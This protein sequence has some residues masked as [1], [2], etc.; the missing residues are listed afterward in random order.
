MS[1]GPRSGG[2]F[3]KK[4]S[5]SADTWGE[6]SL[7]YSLSDLSQEDHLTSAEEIADTADERDFAD[8]DATPESSGPP[9]TPPDRAGSLDRLCSPQGPAQRQPRGRHGKHGRDGERVAGGD[10]G[11][12]PSPAEDEGS[13]YSAFTLPCRRS[14]CLSEGPPGQQGA[15]CAGMQGRRAQ[16]T[17]ADYS[18]SSRRVPGRGAELL[19]SVNGFGTRKSPR[20]LSCS[21]AEGSLLHQLRSGASLDRCET[22]DVT[23]DSEYGDS[24]IDGVG[25]EPLRQ[26]RRCKAM[27]A[28]FSVYSAAGSSTF[29]GS[30]SGSSSGGACGGPGGAGVYENFRQELERS[31]WG[32]P[33]AGE[34]GQEEAGSAASDDRNSTATASSVCQSDAL[35][36]PAHQGTVRKAGEL[37]VKNFLVHKKGKKVEPAARRKWKRYWVSLKG[38]TLFFYETDGRSGIDQNSVPKHAVWA[39]NSIV[40][41]VPEHPKKDF[42]FCLS[43]SLGDAFLFQTS[44]QT[45]LEN[46]ITAL[47]SACAAAVARQHHRDDTVRL[48][49]SEVKKLEKKMDMD[50]KMKKMGEMQLSAVTDAKKRKTILEQIF[51]WE[52]NLEQF[53]MDWF[54]LRCYLASLQGG[55]LPNP[56]R[57]LPNPKRLLACVSR[58]SKLAMGR[59][60]IFSVSSFHALVA[61]RT[62]SGVRRRTQALSRSSSKRKSRF[63]SLWGLDTASKKKSKDRPSIDQVFADGDDPVRKVL[64]SMLEDSPGASLKEEGG[65]VKSIPHHNADSDIWVPDHLTPSWVCLPDDKAQ[66]FIIQTGETALDAL[67][68]ICKTNS[69]DPRSHYLRLKFRME[70]QVRYYTPK[71]DEE[72]CDLL[73]KEIEICSKA[74]K[75]IQFD[76]DESCSIGYGFSVAV[77]E[78][79]GVQQLHV[80]DVKEGGLANAKGLKAGDEILQLNGKD[81][82]ALDVSDMRVAFSQD[83]LCLSVSAVPEGDPQ[84]LCPLPPRRSDGQ[85]DL[86]TDIFSQS[87]ED[88]LEGGTPVRLPSPGE[89]QEDQ[90]QPGGDTPD[91]SKVR[92]QTRGRA[93]SRPCVRGPAATGPLPQRAPVRSLRW[94]RHT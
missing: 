71:L 47:H 46:W 41:A 53:H 44:S 49:R 83:S 42:V 26:S 4:R 24:G 37:A 93:R 36:N 11:G 72:V 79:D 74:T 10:R 59:L 40:Q 92:G 21:P 31:S 66:L 52:Q 88:L 30:D 6:D 82:S 73:Y 5:K 77:V 58:P 64:E 23:E 20:C 62:E 51:L 61:A 33:A 55:E 87:H 25:G 50:E 67:E 2:S 19:V 54:R 13:G 63:S 27:S 17:H 3:Q 90:A 76:R 45:E 35:L 69:L 89:G 29:A 75:L 38:C 85:E 22:V 60:G 43:N 48:L 18:A 56:K 68:G 34:E 15:T 78:E 65:S 81:A 91:G 57:E 94:P 12:A 9:L 39:E 7:E 14:H 32:G 16:T 8:D 80:S 84:L 70:N 28:S 1:D 86:C